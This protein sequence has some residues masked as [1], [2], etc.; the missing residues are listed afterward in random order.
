MSCGDGATEAWCF[1][2]GR[3]VGKTCLGSTSLARVSAVA[4]LKLLLDPLYLRYISIEALGSMDLETIAVGLSVCPLSAY[5]VE[6]LEKA[7]K[8]GVPPERLAN[9]VDHQAFIDARRIWQEKHARNRR[10]LRGYVNER[11][12]DPSM[13]RMK[14]CFDEHMGP[15]PYSPSD[16]CLAAYARHFLRDIVEAL[17]RD[18]ASSGNYWDVNRSLVTPN[19]PLS[20]SQ[21]VGVNPQRHSGHGV[22]SP[23]GSVQANGHLQ[24]ERP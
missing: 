1:P 10:Q 19:V 23:E 20:E 11:A 5:Q 13:D 21:D 15:F 4:A 2:P 14:F 18:G 22:S 3:S 7:I 8:D 24:E 17:E 9:V 16:Q 12:I 6:Q